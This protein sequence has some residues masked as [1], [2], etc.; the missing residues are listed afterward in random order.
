MRGYE[1]SCLLYTASMEMILKISK[2]NFFSSFL[3]VK[4]HNFFNVNTAP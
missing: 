2:K 1:Q 3:I 4:I